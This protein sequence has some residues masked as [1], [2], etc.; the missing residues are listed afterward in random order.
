MPDLD[1]A[2]DQHIR[3]TLLNVHELVRQLNAHLGPTLVAA[4]AGVRDRKLPLKWA[5]PDGP[6]PR[7]EPERRLRMAHRLWGHLSAAENEHVARAW[8]IGA[9]PRL[10][11]ESPVMKLREGDLPAVMNAAKAFIEGTDD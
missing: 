6:T 9:N 5:T 2:N 4:L 3:T 10:G 1:L 7:A 8:F 11:E